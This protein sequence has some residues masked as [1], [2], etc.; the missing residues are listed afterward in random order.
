[1]FYYS[2][3][4]IF[5]KAIGKDFYEGKVTLPAILLYQKA[6]SSERFFL[7]KIFSKKKR[8]EKEFIQTQNLIRKYNSISDCFKR[9]EHFV[10]ISYNALSIFRPTK[11]KEVLQNL[12]SYSLERS[13]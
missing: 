6:N 10:N 5:G 7:K 11:E 9:A 3:N 4:K 1:M 13:F 2:T 8:I 12:A